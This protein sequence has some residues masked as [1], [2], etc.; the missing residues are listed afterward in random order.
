MSNIIKSN[1]K[2]ISRRRDVLQHM[3]LVSLL[4]RNLDHKM[5]EL[6]DM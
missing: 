4:T 5:F 2:V 3:E 1:E 6:N